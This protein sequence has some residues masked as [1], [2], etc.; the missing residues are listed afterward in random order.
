MN[1]SGIRNSGESGFGGRVCAPLVV[2]A[3][4][5]CINLT[6]SGTDE[7][8]FIHSIIWKAGNDVFPRKRENAYQ[9]PEV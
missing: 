5:M 2:I 3:V 4:G 1:S 9:V 7:E 6:E 8:A